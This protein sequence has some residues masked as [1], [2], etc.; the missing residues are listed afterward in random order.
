MYA[1]WDIIIF[2][3]SY[4]TVTNHARVLVKGDTISLDAAARLLL[5]ATTD[6]SYMRSTCL[7]S[8]LLFFN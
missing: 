3:I 7:S 2:Q 1:S 8:L 4:F 6:A 5:G